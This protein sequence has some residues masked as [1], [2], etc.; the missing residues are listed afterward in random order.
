MIWAYRY[1][2]MERARE[3]DA[4]VLL[5][6]IKSDEALETLESTLRRSDVNEYFDWS[7]IGGPQNN[8]PH[9]ILGA[10]IG[11]L[12]PERGRASPAP[13]RT[14]RRPALWCYSS[15]LCAASAMR[16]CFASIAIAAVTT[17]RTAG[18]LANSSTSWSSARSLL[19][20]CDQ[21][22]DVFAIERCAVVAAQMR[23]V[24]LVRTLGLRRGILDPELL[25]E[26]LPHG[27]GAR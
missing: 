7:V 24:D 15:R 13:A 21:R 8:A 2:V 16:R 26:P 27:R 6:M 23:E 20:D 14:E 4:V 18:S 12:I 19:C 11:T 1:H 5:W 9:D 25:R 3:V 22:L 10:F 17:R